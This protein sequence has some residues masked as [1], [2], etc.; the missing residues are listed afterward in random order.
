MENDIFV[1]ITTIKYLE[2]KLIKNIQNPLKIVFYRMTYKV[3]V[4]GESYMDKKPQHFKKSI[5]PVLIYK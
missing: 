3:F 1:I 4:N 5:L 2:I